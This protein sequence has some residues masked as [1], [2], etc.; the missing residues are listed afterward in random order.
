MCELIGD[1]AAKIERIQERYL[2]YSTLHLGRKP[3]K[4]K[5]D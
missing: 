2:Q 3:E 4:K 5:L 1:D